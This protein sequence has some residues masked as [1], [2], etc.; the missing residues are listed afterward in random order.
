MASKRKKS[1]GKVHDAEIVAYS[2][3]L[4]LTRILTLTGYNKA[5][6]YADI[7]AEQDTLVYVMPKS[8]FESVPEKMKKKQKSFIEKREEARMDRISKSSTLVVGVSRSRHSAEISR[9]EILIKQEK[10]GI[11]N[12]PRLSSP[13][14][15]QQSPNSPPPKESL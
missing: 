3:T 15:R 7:I 12:R 10:S 1:R 2:L 8:V 9:Q 6:H 4:T 14:D 11:A 13:E 5:V